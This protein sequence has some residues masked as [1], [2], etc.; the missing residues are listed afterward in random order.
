[1]HLE[2]LGTVENVAAAK[3][4]L[5]QALRPGGTA[6]VPDDEPLL[7]PHIAA[8]DPGVRVIRV[9]AVPDLD[10][11]LNL[12]KAWELRNAAA[13]LACCRA[14]GH[15]PPAGARDRG[16]GSRR[17]AARSAPLAG[18]GT[19]IE[20][21]YN[22]NPI[23]MHAALA[24]LAGRPGR[25]VAVLADMMELGPDEAPLPPRGRARRP[26]RP[27]STCWSAVGE[28]AAGYVSGA[29]G[30]EAVHI[31]TVEEAI[32]PGARAD[33]ATGDTVLLKGSRSMRA[34]ADRR[35][36]A[37]LA[38]SLSVPRVLISAI[39]RGHAPHVPGAEV[40]R[41]AARQ[42]GGPVRAPARADPGGPRREAGH[43]RPWAGC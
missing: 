20:D 7:E 4:E 37:P 33:R 2:L 16:G 18:G 23:A 31:A 24:D 15:V 5:L 22:A 21:C 8:L 35:G 26:P 6:V 29:D 43:A 25:R 30:L 11:D 40:H 13:A 36:P 1:M 12:S 14:L 27:A 9:G 17:C 42:R 39:S 32:E 19:L 41:L 3:A 38:A 28:R 10:L 34:R